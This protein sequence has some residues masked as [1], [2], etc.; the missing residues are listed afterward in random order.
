MRGIPAKR[1]RLPGNQR[2]HRKGHRQIENHREAGG[3]PAVV[4]HRAMAHTHRLLS[5]HAAVGCDHD[6][7]NR[8]WIPRIIGDRM[9]LSGQRIEMRVG[10]EGAAQ[11]AAEIVIGQRSEHIVEQYRRAPRFDQRPGLSREPNHVGVDGVEIAVAGARRRPLT[12]GG[13]DLGRADTA[14]AIPARATALD[15]KTV[16]HAVAE[17]P[18]VASRIGGDRV[19]ADAQIAPIESQRDRAGYRQIL[20]RHFFRHRRVNSAQERMRTVRSAHTPAI[21]G[22]E[23][24]HALADNAAD[25]S[26]DDADHWALPPNVKSAAASPQSTE[27]LT[28]RNGCVPEAVVAMKTPQGLNDRCLRCGDCRPAHIRRAG[29]YP[30]RDIERSPLSLYVWSATFRSVSGSY[31]P[32]VAPALAAFD[33][34]SRACPRAV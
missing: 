6:M 13:G 23:R 3:D 20:D 8:G 14:I 2:T 19:R 16:D 30:P 15:A 4:H 25:R 26:F 34:L 21:E 31:P 5:A 1:E 17:E 27:A 11:R 7:M 22:C 10:A 28:Q 9:H 32:N 33:G 24:R 29:L 12:Q 18:V